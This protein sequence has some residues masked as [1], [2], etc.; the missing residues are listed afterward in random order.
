MAIDKV[1]IEFDARIK[2]LEKDMAKL[3]KA[4]EKP[5][6]AATKTTKSIEK[7]FNGL[8]TVVKG[9]G[10]AIAGAF[11]VQKII[12]FGTE[13]VKLASQA[14]GV[15]IAFDRLNNPKLLDDLRKA[16]RGT[17]SDLQLMQQAVRAE[18]FKIPLERLATLLEFARRRATATGESV[19]FL[20]QSIVIGIG[21]KSPLII[22]NLGISA[23]RVSAEF[24]KTGDFAQAVANIVEEELA[25]MGDDIDTTANKLARVSAAWDNFKVSAGNALIAVGAAVLQ[26]GG[27]IGKIEELQITNIELANKLGI[28]LEKIQFVAGGAGLQI[29]EFGKNIAKGKDEINEASIAA[30][31]F[32][33]NIIELVDV[34]EEGEVSLTKLGAELI[35]TLTDLS[36]ITSEVTE[37]QERS[38]K[39]I[40]A[41]IT[42]Q[43]N[44]IKAESERENIIPI[45]ENV[46]KL[47]EEL[48]RLLG[49]QTEAEK[50]LAKVREKAAKDAEAQREKEKKDREEA[51]QAFFEFIDAEEQARI[52][53]LK[54][55]A[56]TEKKKVDAIIEQRERDLKNLNE[57]SDQAKLIVER[58]QQEITDITQKEQDIR[59]GSSEEGLAELGKQFTDFTAAQ[60]NAIVLVVGEIEKA[61]TDTIAQIGKLR[62]AQFDREQQQLSNLENLIKQRVEAGISSEEE[63]AQIINDIRKRQF[64]NEKELALKQLKIDTASALIKSLAKGLFGLPQAILIAKTADT[65][66]EIIESQQFEGFAKGKEFVEGPGTGTSDSVLHRLSKGERIVTAADNI[67]Y[68][69]PL[70]DMH[71]GKFDKNWIKKDVVVNAL[72][73]KES[74][75]ANMI[76]SAALQ[77]FDTYQLERNQKKAI[78]KSDINTDKI[79]KA[80]KDTT[81]NHEFMKSRRYAV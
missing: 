15:K 1:L 41:E 17:V 81:A 71:I 63:G 34:T 2:G 3:V 46:I 18:N 57:N 60:I 9:I 56:D 39:V 80:I 27:A 12:S 76:A 67:T 16:T 62:Q 19:E 14:E 53:L 51:R 11:A 48:A 21:R 72:Q 25:D 20:T 40:E 47:E 31:K 32:G 28:E 43:K 77:D 24:K 26:F 59:I 55:T 70:H 13:A 50:E 64:E 33:V 30:Q 4:I 74:L 79:V 78:S 54:I 5:Q 69:D 58:S 35:S 10:V 66:R 75:A 37:K 29:T 44:L 22:D 49:K 45:Q 65:Q 52:D 7:S 38:V 6:A 42:A 61:I 23:A 68:N 73:K 36:R 8:G